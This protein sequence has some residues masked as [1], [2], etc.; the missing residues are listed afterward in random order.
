M[1][2]QFGRN[3]CLDCALLIK[4]EFSSFQ[5]GRY[6]YCYLIP[7]TVPGTWWVL[8]KS[9]IHESIVDYRNYLCMSYTLIQSLFI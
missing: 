8:N 5:T 2:S 6:S 9:L 7:T 3:Y 4:H 1:S